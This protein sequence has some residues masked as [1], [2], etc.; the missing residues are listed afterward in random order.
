MTVCD[1]GQTPAGDP[2]VQQR[3]RQSPQQQQQQLW[4]WQ[5]QWQW[6]VRS[7][8]SLQPVERRSACLRVCVCV[9][10]E[11]E[12]GGGNI[13]WRHSRPCAV[14]GTPEVSDSE[15]LVDWRPSNE[16]QKA[17]RPAMRNRRRGVP[18]IRIHKT[19]GMLACTISGQVLPLT[20]GFLLGTIL[21]MAT[22]SQ[23]PPRES[24]CCP[25]SQ[26]F[27][28][29]LVFLFTSLIITTGPSYLTTCNDHRLS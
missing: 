5:W 20:I 2:S 1:N 7:Y 3:T 24:L 14:T 11:R 4:Q 26:S 23:T 27:I 9:C 21:S 18:G 6:L 10:V 19:S 25:E 22:G 8:R 17:R 13:W 16:T 12:R 15:E 29:G 28:V